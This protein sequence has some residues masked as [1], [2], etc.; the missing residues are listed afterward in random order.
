LKDHGAVKDFNERMARWWSVETGIIERLYDVSEGITLALVE[1]GFHASL[2]AHGESTLPPDE[3]VAILGDHR[4]ALDMVMDVVGGTRSLTVGWIKE[5]QAL[6]TR[7][8][9]T[10]KGRDMFGK[11]VDIPLLRGAYKE[12]PNNPLTRDGRG[13]HE[14]CPPEQVASEMDR[15]VEIYHSLPAFPEVRSAWLHH[16]F[17]QIHPFQDGNG[18]VARALASI[19]FIKAGLFP[20]LVHRKEREEYLDALHSADEGDL[21]PLVGYFARVEQNLLARAISEAEHA[22][23]AAAGLSTVLAS[24]R[25]KREQRRDEVVQS[26]E[27]L[28]QRMSALIAETSRVLES[29]RKEVQDAVPGITARPVQRCDPGRRH[30]FRQQLIDL[31]NKNGY[32]VDLNEPRDWVRLQ[33]RDGGVTD[34]VVATHFIGNPSPGAAIAVVFVEHRDQNEPAGSQAPMDVAAEP[35]LLVADE[36]EVAQRHRFLQWLDKARVQALAQ[37]TRFL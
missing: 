6:L 26:R 16:A 29:V 5:L 4:E 33:L 3:L 11:M 13:L 22:V 8:Q 35:L 34:I 23:S 28:A 17:T 36:D 24:A 27:L 14:Y 15:L 21:K 9:P 31:G 2:I 37:W 12:R 30:W 32:W 7:N 18:R 25:Q 1:K 10:A 20:V 19:D